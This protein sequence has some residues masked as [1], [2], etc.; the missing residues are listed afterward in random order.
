MLVK[1]YFFLYI[2]EHK[3][4]FDQKKFLQRI[5]LYSRGN[6]WLKEHNKRFLRVQ[7]VLTLTRF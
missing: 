3:D 4:Q 6:Y 7:K 2:L 5:I 1:S